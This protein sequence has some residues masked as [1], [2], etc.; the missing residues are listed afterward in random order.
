[1]RN[2][3]RY[4]HQNKAEGDCQLVTTCNAYYHLTGT[5]VKQDSE[6]YDELIDLAACRHG[7]AISIEKVWSRLGIWEKKRLEWYQA[8]FQLEESTN[9]LFEVNIWHKAY[10]FHSVLVVAYNKEVDALRVTNL[11]RCTS[12][13]GWIFAE[14]FNMLVREMGHPKDGRQE[15]LRLR[16]NI[17]RNIG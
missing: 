13:D 15:L 11:K 12:L 8:R 3:Y 5:S 9:D 14:D 16:R 7:S 6:F 1:M 4:I 17:A 2:W 10:G